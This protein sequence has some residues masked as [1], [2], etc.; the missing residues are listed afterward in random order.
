[1]RV[2]PTF[3]RL[4]VRP[5]AAEEKKGNLYMPGSAQEKP[6]RGRVIEVGPGK[7]LENGTVSPL[8]IKTGNTVIYGKY[9]GAELKI[10]GVDHLILKADEIIAIVD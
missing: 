1:M 3:D 9:C 6:T 10:D 4:L 2:R 7:L 5:E 8:D